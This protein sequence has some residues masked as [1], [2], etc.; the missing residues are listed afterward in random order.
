MRVFETVNMVVEEIS[1]G[2]TRT[3]SKKEYFV[4]DRTGKNLY[5]AKDLDE[6]KQWIAAQ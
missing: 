1:I 5:V 3:S 6:A 2:Q 4:D